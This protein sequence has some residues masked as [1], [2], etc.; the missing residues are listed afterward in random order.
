MKDKNIK[1]VSIVLDIL[2]II[3]LII[4][5]LNNYTRI[6]TSLLLVMFSLKIV[7]NFKKITKKDLY[8]SLVIMT[9]LAII[10]YMNIEDKDFQFNGYTILTLIVAISMLYILIKYFRN[11]LSILSYIVTL[12]VICITFGNTEL[13]NKGVEAVGKRYTEEYANEILKNEKFGRYELKRVYGVQDSLRADK[14]FKEN[15][16]KIIKVIEE[17]IRYTNKVVKEVDSDKLSVLSE[18]GIEF[19]NQVNKRDDCTIDDLYNS[20]YV[21]SS[22]VSY[23]GK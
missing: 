6:N 16:Y 2:L 8:C 15:L 3:S 23:G 5:N 10:S 18:I 17:D 22:I 21:D 9:I 7:L 19:L 4:L 13:Y 12:T 20:E 11:D 1:I 14:K